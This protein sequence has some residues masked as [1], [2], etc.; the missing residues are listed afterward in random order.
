MIHFFGYSFSD[1]G[2]IM[3]GYDLSLAAK[4]LKDVFST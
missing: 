3:A 1:S 2:G 4:A